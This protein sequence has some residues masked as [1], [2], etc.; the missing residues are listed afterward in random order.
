MLWNMNKLYF[1]VLFFLSLM[2]IFNLA[3]ANLRITPAVVNI[4]AEPMALC[5]NKYVVTNIDENTVTVTVTKED[6]KNYS[7]NDSSVTVDRWLEIE[8]TKFDLGPKETIEVPFKV[9]TDK[10]MKG[11]VS[12]MVVFTIDGG[13]IQVLMKQPIYITIKGTERVDFEIDSLQMATSERDGEVYYNM[14]VKNHGNVHIRHKGVIEI[15]SRKTGNIVKSID[16]DE[17]F[18]TY[19]QDSRDFSGPIFKGTDLVKGK[20]K[21]VF[22]IKAFDKQV[23]KSINFKVSK[24]GEVVTN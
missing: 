6:W 19:A 21:A 1:K 17:T 7:G 10:N 5:E 9:I 8:K 12:G 4:N 14:V 3:Y 23:T 15:Y 18:P 13:M 20:Y 2:F 16:I 11:S 22:K 24:L